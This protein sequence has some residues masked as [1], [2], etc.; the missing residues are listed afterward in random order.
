MAIREILTVL[1][2]TK[3][4]NEQVLKEKH[5]CKAMAEVHHCTALTA[6]PWNCYVGRIDRHIQCPLQY[7]SIPLLLSSSFSKIIGLSN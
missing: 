2:N 6:T 7:S 1:L 4:S 3:A 5:F